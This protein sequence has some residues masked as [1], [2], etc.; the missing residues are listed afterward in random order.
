MIALLSALLG[1][2]GTAA[3]EYFKFKQDKS[4]KIHEL[5]LLKYQTQLDAQRADADLD[6]SLSIATSEQFTSVQESY[7]ADITANAKLK[8]SWIVAYSAS[9]RPTIT[10]LFFVLY[11]GVKVAQF[12]LLL[13]P[14]FPWQQAAG[15]AQALVGVWTPADMTVFEAVIGFWFGSRVRNEKR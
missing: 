12:N 8:N 4:D 1:Y 5:E 10:Y 15:F 14:S 7:R 6:K 13:N 9:V 11:A 3:N 2:L